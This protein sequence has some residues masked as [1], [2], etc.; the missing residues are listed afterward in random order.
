M[1]LFSMVHLL[2]HINV[3]GHWIRIRPVPL[4]LLVQSGKDFHRLFLPSR[5][6]SRSGKVFHALRPGLVPELTEERLLAVENRRRAA[7]VALLG[8]GELLSKASSKPSDIAVASAQ[9]R[10]MGRK[11][12]SRVDGGSDSVISEATHVR[13]SFR[14][15]AGGDGP[16]TEHRE[17]RRECAGEAGG[18]SLNGRFTTK[19]PNSDFKNGYQDLAPE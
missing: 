10:T 16:D 13:E 17:L 8:E 4:Q 9:G 7:A 18:D 1:L 14:G 6:D 11:W 19:S 3:V 15:E 5:F 12:D 2:F